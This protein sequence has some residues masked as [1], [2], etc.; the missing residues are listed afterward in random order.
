MR[1]SQLTGMRAFSLV[2]FGQVISLTGSSMTLFGLTIWAFQLTGQ[3]T[4]LALVAFFGFA[5]AVLVS[6]IAGVLV[7]RWN[8]KLVMMLSD[9]GAGAATIVVFILYATGNLQLWHLYA[10]AAFSGVFQSFQ[11][12]AYSAAISMMLPRSQYAR[13]QG[14][15]TLADSGSGILAPI[16]AGALLGVIG[17]AGIMIIDIVTFTFAIGALLL[18]HVP[19][20]ARTEEGRQG[21][22]SI[23]HEAAY[24]FQYIWAR[25]SLLGLLMTFLFINLSGSV[26]FPLVAPMVL[27]RT[28]SN[29]L[30]LGG[31]QSAGA[32]GGVLGGVLL[33]AWGGPKRRVHGVLLG[34]AV[35]GALTCVL[36]LGLTPVVWGAALLVSSVSIVITN[37]SSQAIWQSKVVPDVQGRVFATRR[38]LAQ[39]LGP[40]GLL[41]AGPLADRVFEPAMIPGGSLTGL[42]GAIV[43]PGPG[44]GMGILIALMGVVGV[45]VALSAYLFPAIRQAET[46]LPDHEAARAQPEAGAAPS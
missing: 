12:P 6:P 21:Q 20:P 17:L 3:A 8:R 24:G 45:I 7:D 14:M 28:G 38:L 2:W 44:A 36:G 23:L 42:F 37:A 34:M 41:A 15:I 13:A 19:Q 27:A 10:A 31:V 46:L 9:L 35:T 11:F 18:V 29:E 1:R 26:A 33:T 32:L 30:V 16:L 22:G 5:P 43:E 39:I 40:L 25:P 4:A